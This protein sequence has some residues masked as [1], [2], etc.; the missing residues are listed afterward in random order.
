[1]KDKTYA[2]ERD[3][4]VKNTIMGMVRSCNGMSWELLAESTGLGFSDL[5]GAIGQL[6][7]EGRIVLQ[8]TDPPGRESWYKSRQEYIFSRFMDLLS[9]H[10][11]ERSVQFY[12]SRLCLTSKYLSVIVKQVSGKTPTAWIKERVIQEIK[13]RLCHTQ[14][15]V[16]EISY[17][18]NF[19]N[20]SFF[21]KYFK[22]ATG[23][24]PF[25]YRIRYGGENRRP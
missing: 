10:A 9:A 2:D 7:Q 15:S 16:K 3:E 6:M 19:P 18:L 8:A 12:A 21:G 11:E 13:Y 5:T 23:V 20:A 17:T 22:R 25:I 24:S 4:T 14:Q 1:M